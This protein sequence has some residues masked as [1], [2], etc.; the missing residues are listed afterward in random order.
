MKLSIPASS[1]PGFY[2]RTGRREELR[3]KSKLPPKGITNAASIERGYS[4]LYLP[5]YPQ[6]SVSSALSINACQMNTWMNEWMK[7]WKEIRLLYLNCRGNKRNNFLK[8]KKKSPFWM[9]FWKHMGEELGVTI[10]SVGHSPGCLH[11]SINW[12]GWP[13]WRHVSARMWVQASLQHTPLV[14]LRRSCREQLSLLP[15]QHPPPPDFIARNSSVSLWWIH[16]LSTPN[17]CGSGGMYYTSHIQ[18]WPHDLDMSN[19]SHNDW[20]RN[21]DMTKSG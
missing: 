7:E 16:L 15:A 4:M 11:V 19:W 20:L 21:G 12:L 17:P 3:K 6:L 14:I 18:W 2:S 8:L 5:S 10:P 13:G 1:S 9:T